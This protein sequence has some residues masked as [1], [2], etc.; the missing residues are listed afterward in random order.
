MLFYF[1]L[2]MGGYLVYVLHHGGYVGKYLIVFA[3]QDIVGII[4][5]CVDEIGIVYQASA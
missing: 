1:L 5:G 4:T 3:L 2:E